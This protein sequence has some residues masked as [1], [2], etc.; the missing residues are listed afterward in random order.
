[1]MEDIGRAF[2]GMIA[3]MTVIIVLSAP[4]AVWKLVEIVIWLFKHISVTIN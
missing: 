2:S 3:G 4:L 1:M